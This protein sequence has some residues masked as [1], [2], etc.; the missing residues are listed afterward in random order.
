VHLAELRL[1]DFR[2][3]TDQ[4][5]TLPPG[6]VAIVGDNGQG[7][8]NLLEAIYY[9][10]VFRSFRGAPD[11]QLV[12]FGTDVFRLDARLE[13]EAGQ[14]EIGVGYERRGRKKVTLDGLE[15]DRL[16]DQ[17]GRVGAVIFSP[18]D[19]EIVSGPPGARRR[20]LDIVL[21]LSVPGY[22]AALQRYRQTLSQRNALLRRG[23]SSAAV[24]AWDA[25]LVR[26]GARLLVARL[27]WVAERAPGFAEHYAR[28][29]GGET[30]SLR[31]RSA[32]PLEE[33]TSEASAAEAFAATLAER[34]DAEARRQTTVVGPHRDDL[35]LTFDDRELRAYGSGG[36]RRTAAI[37]L[38]MVEAETVRERRGMEPIFLL[39]DVFAELDASRAE[40]ILAWVDA[41]S[42][43][44]VIVTAPKPA[45]VGLR[46]DSLPRLTISGGVVSAL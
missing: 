31:Y 12:R 40:R 22:L 9:L 46:G 32:I 8:T 34:R 20:F 27:Q 30:G 14:V 5:I 3:F 35:A 11:D 16:S 21:S 18:A 17:V 39:D 36:Q 25:G 24:S 33:G 37:A 44:Q 42:R 43:G 4:R 45:D 1:R 38:R 15:A 28:V 2:N 41:E 7:K 10:E 26:E 23:A 13:G 19:L 6:G 29:A